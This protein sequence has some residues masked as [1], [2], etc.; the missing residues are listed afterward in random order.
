MSENHSYTG[1]TWEAGEVITKDKLNTVETVVKNIDKEVVDARGS[2]TSVDERLTNL[3]QVADEQPQDTA[4]KIWFD[5]TTGN[6]PIDVPTMED[7][8]NI[9]ADEYSTTGRY[10]IDDYC[11]HEGALYRCVTTITADEAWTAAHWIEVQVGDEFYSLKKNLADIDKVKANKNDIAEVAVEIDKHN[12]ALIDIGD[13][14]SDEQEKLADLQNEVKTKANVNDIAAMSI[15]VD[16]AMQ[17]IDELNGNLTAK[18]S[19]NDLANTAID[20]DRAHNRIDELKEEIGKIAVSAGQIMDSF[21]QSENMIERI[22]TNTTNLETQQTQIAALNTTLRGKI[23]KP[24]D[25]GNQG[26]VLSADGSGGV[27]WANPFEPSDEQIGEAV[28]EWLNNNPEATTTVV[29]GSVT[30]QKLSQDVQDAILDNQG[31]IDNTVSNN[32]LYLAQNVRAGINSASD[33]HVNMFD[34]LKS[35]LIQYAALFG[36]NDGIGFIFFTD[37]HNANRH[38]GESPYEMLEGLRLIRTSFENSPA[39]YVVCGGDWLNYGHEYDEALMMTGRIRNLC[40]T[41]IG[42]KCYII[43]GNHDFNAHSASMSEIDES[44]VRKLWFDSDVG[45]YK[46]ETN[47]TTAFMFD[48]G[49]ENRGQTTY[50]LN[51]VKWFSDYLLTNSKPHLFGFSHIIHTPSYIAQNSADWLAE[52]L[53]LV[54][55]AFNRRDAITIG[56]QEYNFSQATGTFHFMVCGHYHSDHIFKRNNIPIDMTEAFV[57][58]NTFDL[59]YANFDTAKLHL[60]RYGTGTSRTMN[61]IPNNGY[62]A[63]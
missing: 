22:Q 62:E 49:K 55:N 61:I 35:K 63:I 3:I 27:Q 10:A 50:R 6:D 38:Y 24:N 18:A 4:N 12:A 57:H 32:I 58:S 39:M 2:S 17:R 11:L 28:S 8:N 30:M 43:L 7:L 60:I 41:E 29:N 14:L 21:I 5:T 48:S 54:A 51:Q 53:T 15:E 13:T 34:S 46:I 40:T 19:V 9:I 47:K 52:Q 59:C 45:Y 44:T 1:H 25:D 56:Q 33:S 42:E 37:P 26:Q 31:A 20:I 23:T 36:D 16:T